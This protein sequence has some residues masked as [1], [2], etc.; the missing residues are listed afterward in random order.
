MT[1]RDTR[2]RRAIENLVD[3][4]QIVVG[5]AGQV[6][7]SAHTTAEEAVTLETSVARAVEALRQLQPSAPGRAGR[8][9]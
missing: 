9:R 4:M 6:R 8:R 7:L 3:A 5:L 2:V 1:R